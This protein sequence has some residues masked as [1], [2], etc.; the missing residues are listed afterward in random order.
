MWFI[1]LLDH[2]VL[3]QLQSCEILNHT[4]IYKPVYFRREP[5]K[6]YLNAFLPLDESAGR[7][8]HHSSRL[9]T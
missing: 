1:I 9:I 5:L 3:Q 2:L 4:P 6:Y 7:H 8:L